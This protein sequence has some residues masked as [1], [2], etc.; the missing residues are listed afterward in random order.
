M[1]ILAFD[2]ALGACS[3]AVLQTGGTA[4]RLVRAHELRARGH[5]E[6]LMPMIAHVMEEA[7]IGYDALDRIAVTV[8]P[9]TFTGMR[10]GVAAARGLALA[11]GLPLVGATTLAVMAHQVLTGEEAGRG[12]PLA[13]CVDARRGQI[14]CQVFGVDGQA[15]APPFVATPEAAAER[16]TDGTLTAAGSG[17]QALAAAAAMR[18]GSVTAGLPDLQPD[19][20]ALAHLAMALEPAPTP[21]A[22]LYLR[23]P[24]AKPQAGGAVAWRT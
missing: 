14:Y 21:V 11:T 1:N 9:G 20:A 19:A 6:A 15:L 24:D 16:L 17:A 18:A 12:G 23:P 13:I 5:A 7:G 4:P 10:V 8:G 2:T 22:P 3:A